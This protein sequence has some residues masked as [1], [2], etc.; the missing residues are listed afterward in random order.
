MNRVVSQSS[1]IRH[2]Q[3]SFLGVALLA[4]LAAPAA[5]GGSTNETKPAPAC[6]PGLSI[7]CVGSGQCHGHQACKADGSGFETCSCD[8]DG[9]GAGGAGTG[10]A[11]VGA[12]GA[13]IGAG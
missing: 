3:W 12:G 10:G 11:E 1:R 7:A 2:G 13:V 6:A 8:S 5:C 9:G 4:S